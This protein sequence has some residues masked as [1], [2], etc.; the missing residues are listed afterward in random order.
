DPAHTGA[1]AHARSA[2][3]PR[4]CGQQ[5]VH[6]GVERAGRLRVGFGGALVRSGDFGG[7]RRSRNTDGGGRNGA[8]IS[9][10]PPTRTLGGAGRG[11]RRSGGERGGKGEDLGRATSASF[12]P[13]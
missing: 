3:R 8:R 1:D 7:Q 6:R 12:V 10:T 13:L 5:P 4:G 2:T 11:E 9:R